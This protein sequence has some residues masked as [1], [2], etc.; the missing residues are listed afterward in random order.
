MA[1]K[2]IEDIKD[3]LDIKYNLQ[4]FKLQQ[5]E[6]YIDK[7]VPHKKHFNT[8]DINEARTKIV[9]L[10]KTNDYDIEMIDM[11]S[12]YLHDISFFNNFA[13]FVHDSALLDICA[14]RDLINQYPQDYTELANKYGIS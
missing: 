9:E 14:N 11:V 1:Q 4:Q 2:L 13:L 10:F 3:P 7:I 5:V 12:Q 6:T 8:N